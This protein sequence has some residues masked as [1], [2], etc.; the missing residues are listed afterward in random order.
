VF[1]IDEDLGAEVKNDVLAGQPK[2]VRYDVLRAIEI[3]LHAG[4]GSK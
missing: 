4:E 2:E 1:G 3:I